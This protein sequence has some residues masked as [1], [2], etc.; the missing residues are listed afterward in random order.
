MKSST[1]KYARKQDYTEHFNWGNCLP[2]TKMQFIKINV[3]FCT[4]AA[5]SFLHFILPPLLNRR[6]MVSHVLMVFLKKLL[7]YKNGC[8]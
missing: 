8:P 2:N 6:L 3:R 7:Q 4:Q 5:V 1:Y